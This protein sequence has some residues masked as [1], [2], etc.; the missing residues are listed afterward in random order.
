MTVII[1]CASCGYT[2]DEEILQVAACPACHGL[3]L[4]ALPGPADPVVPYE[5]NALDRKLL[6]QLRIQS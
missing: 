2:Y 4:I 3:Y 5:L 6:S 1:R